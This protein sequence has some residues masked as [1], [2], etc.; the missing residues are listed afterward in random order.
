MSNFVPKQPSSAAKVK[1]NVWSQMHQ[2]EKD[3]GKRNINIIYNDIILNISAFICCNCF[4]V[5]TPCY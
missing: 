3:F 2:Y 5:K 4:T 1:K